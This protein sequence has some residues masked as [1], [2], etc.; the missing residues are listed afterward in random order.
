MVETYINYVYQLYLSKGVWRVPKYKETNVNK[1]KLF[2]ELQS[3]IQK[4]IV[5]FLE[6]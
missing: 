1:L 3:V 5:I 2:I 6:S 4:C